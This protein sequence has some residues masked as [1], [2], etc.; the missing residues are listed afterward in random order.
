MAIVA[1]FSA[2][3]CRGGEVAARV[4]GQLNSSLYGPEIIEWAAKE[5][6]VP[7]EKLERAMTG[8][9][10][11]FNQF[12]RE[13]ERHT[14]YLKASAA[15]LTEHEAWAHEGYASL[16]IPESISHALRVCLVAD[17]EYRL[18][19]ALETGALTEK[20]AGRRIAEDHEQRNN[21]TQFLF[22]R[23]PWDSRLYDMKIPMH[24]TSVEEAASSIC[25]YAQRDI[26]RQTEACKRAARDFIVSTNA[27]VALVENG[28]GF[29][30]E[31][32]GGAAKVFINR[33]ALRQGK[34]EADLRNILKEIPGIE[35]VVFERISEHSYGPIN[36]FYRIDAVMPPKVLLV[37]DE[38]EYVETLSERLQMRKFGAAVA[39]DGE[40]AML[41]VAK[42][43]P[44]VMVL[45]L[46][47][48]GID[49]LDVLRRVKN[50]R[51]QITVIVL[52]GHGTEKDEA[53]SRELGAFCYLEKPVNIETLAEA[54]KKASE[55]RRLD[56]GEIP[57]GKD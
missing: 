54:I 1:I 7:Q 40:E 4:A 41:L 56:S 19:T 49:G 17:R 44:E 29:R 51:P 53:L 50:E 9:P 42:D 27:A 48:P 45:D 23:G 21:W 18:K 10:S 39:H 38:K 30:V 37:D 32:R 5:Y 11:I 12:T 55:Q 35:S 3:Y 24:S 22:S 36:P 34:L 25:E 14:A 20:E 13:R 52:T 47:M 31:S 57:E 26:L 2:S 43:E 6:G 15:R 46:R 16:L 28:Y 33:R 8:P